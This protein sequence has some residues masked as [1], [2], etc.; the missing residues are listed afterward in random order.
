MATISK[1]LAISI[2]RNQGVYRD[3][4]VAYAVFEFMNTLTGEHCYAIVYDED[5]FRRYVDEQSITYILWV[6][7]ISCYTAAVFRSMIHDS[8]IGK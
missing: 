6:K 7:E 3:D 1:E 5:D 8:K 2:A 4:P